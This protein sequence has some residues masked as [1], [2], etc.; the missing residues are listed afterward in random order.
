[1]KNDQNISS[2][3]ESDILMETSRQ[4][5]KIHFSSENYI[6]NGISF[7]EVR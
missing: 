6:I 3:I 5:R 4:H 1:M 7:K 2:E